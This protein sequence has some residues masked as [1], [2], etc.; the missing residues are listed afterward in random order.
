MHVLIAG[1]YGATLY[2]SLLAYILIID[3]PILTFL[4]LSPVIISAAIAGLL[5]LDMSVRGVSWAWKRWR[6]A[7]N[8]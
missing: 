6:P 4:M 3:G 7:R 1:L 2:L 5:A 8:N